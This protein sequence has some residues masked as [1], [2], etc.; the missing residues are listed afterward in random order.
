M[1]AHIFESQCIISTEPNELLHEVYHQ[2]IESFY[3]TSDGMK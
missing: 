3:K 1:I 2:N